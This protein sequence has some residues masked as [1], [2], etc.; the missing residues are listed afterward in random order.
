M[1]IIITGAGISGL[2]TYLFLRKHLPPSLSYTIHI[3]ESHRPRPSTTTNSQP[4]SFETLSASTALVGGGLGV[5]PN[6]MRTLYALSP[7]LHT[8]V[9]AQGFPCEKFLFLGENG[10]T[11]GVQ[12]TGDNG[13]YDGPNGREEVCVSSSRHGL[14]QCLMEA[15]GEG[16][17]RYRKVVGVD[18]KGS[19][20][21]VRF[22]DGGEEECDLLVGADGVR[23]VVRGCLFGGEY[24]PRYTGASG[25][26]GFINMDLPER[27]AE[28]KAMVFTFGGSGFFGYAS[29]GPAEAK[30]VMWWSTFD[31]DALPSREDL[32]PDAI[33]VEM[34]KRHAN[35]A[36][37]AVR[38]IMAKAEVESIYPTWVLPDLPHWGENGIVLVGDAAHALSPT[39]GQGAS[40]ALEDAQTL[41]LLLAETL[42]RAHD[43][44]AEGMSTAEKEKEAVALSIKLLYEIRAP[45][46]KAIAE[47]GRKMDGGKRK[48]SK[49]EEYGMYCFLWLMMHVAILR[50]LALG[51]VNAQLYGWSAKAEVEKA[52]KGVESLP[53]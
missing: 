25:I 31:T 44:G 10:W 33:K 18:V 13:G 53:S 37:P 38:D 45:R 3:Y 34:Q 16:V 20:K 26:G 24:G 41:S 27:V 1:R 2:S 42:K 49:I 28:H 39:T 23:S 7:S 9:S 43:S 15:V 40:Q 8:A 47:R 6:G 21:I 32:D 11:L 50:K 29:G 48:M 52:L 12:R 51:D 30:N 14:W 4:H 35:S 17:V 19:V 36:D 5:S 46:I 22:E